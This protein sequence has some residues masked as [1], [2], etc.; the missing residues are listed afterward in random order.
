V[1]AREDVGITINACRCYSARKI[2]GV[3]VGPSPDW[4]RTKLEAIGLRSINNIVDV[5]NYVMMELG[6]PLH[7]FDAAR[8]HGNLRVRAA[9]EG[10]QFL[11]LDGKTYTLAT[12]DITMCGRRA[13]RG[14]RRSDGWRRTRA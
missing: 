1:A 5:T 14:H 12:D 6:Q 9:G 11:A 4:L 10:E 3:K 13:R 7:A 2:E 8:L